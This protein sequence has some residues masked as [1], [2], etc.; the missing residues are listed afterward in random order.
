MAEILEKWAKSG[1]KRSHVNNQLVTCRTVPKSGF[2]WPCVVAARSR[3]LPH[4][5]AKADGLTPKLAPDAI[6][7]QAIQPP[8]PEMCPVAHA[9][10]SNLRSLFKDI[11]LF[12]VRGAKVRARR[13]SIRSKSERR[14]RNSA[15]FWRP[16]AERYGRSPNPPGLLPLLRVGAPVP[17]CPL[18][19]RFF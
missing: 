9:Q 16:T 11:R 17:G 15:I 4:T 12:Q 5:P 7:F 1:Q 2:N 6:K 8:Q 13:C 19:H 14:T 18:G 10:F 3:K